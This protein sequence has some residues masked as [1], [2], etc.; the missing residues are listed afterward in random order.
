[1]L[2]RPYCPY[3]ALPTELYDCLY[4]CFESYPRQ[5]IYTEQHQNLSP[6]PSLPPI[7]QSEVIQGLLQYKIPIESTT[8]TVPMENSQ[9]NTLEYLHIDQPT[10][11][12]YSAQVINI[13]VIDR[14][15]EEVQY[16]SQRTTPDL[17][18]I[19]E[20]PAETI[21]YTHENT[22]YQPPVSELYDWNQTNQQLPGSLKTTG[23]VEHTIEAN[24][25]QVPILKQSN[26]IENLSQQQSTFYEENRPSFLHETIANELQLPTP[27]TEEIHQQQE[28]IETFP[29]THDCKESKVYDQLINY[30]VRYQC[31]SRIPTENI[32]STSHTIP[33]INEN[34]RLCLVHC[35]ESIQDVYLPPP[36]LHRTPPNPQSLCAVC[37][38]VSGKSLIKKIV[39]KQIEDNQYESQ[40]YI[41]YG[42]VIDQLATHVSVRYGNNIIE[43][44]GG[45]SVCAGDNEQLHILDFPV[46]ISGEEHI[47]SIEPLV[48]RY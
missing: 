31:P 34:A 43:E 17:S 39:Y 36:L 15:I 21:T 19:N 11:I 35:P 46:Y 29:L 12:T 6:Q 10:N 42:S 3:Q 1:M 44:T 27:I 20:Q 7:Y 33:R 28:N 13:P 8:T 24:S 45:A 41:D 9:Q 2:S 14:E 23:T 30:P 16:T 5:S 18:F 22:P 48:P 40:S 26:T 32:P 4:R 25:T 47:N 37:C 38:C